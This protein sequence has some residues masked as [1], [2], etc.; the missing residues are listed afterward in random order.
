MSICLRRREFI[1]GLGGAAVTAWPLVARAQQ[2]PAVPVI[3]FLNSE[4]PIHYAPMA[5]A[6]RQGLN[7]AGYIDGRNVA[8]EYRWADEQYDRLP[9]QPDKS[10]HKDPICGF[11][12]SG[13]YAGTRD[14]HP[15]CE[16]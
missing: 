10:G 5:G 13:P 12:E 8:I 14:A 3:G 2:R 6:F 9:R 15:L 16:H 11:P 1:A 4:S 7:E